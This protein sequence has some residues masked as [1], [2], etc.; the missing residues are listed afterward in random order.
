MFFTRANCRDKDTYFLFRED[1]TEVVIVL[2]EGKIKSETPKLSKEERDFF[3]E[4]KLK[5]I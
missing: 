2:L 4:N 3:I 1:G 5:I